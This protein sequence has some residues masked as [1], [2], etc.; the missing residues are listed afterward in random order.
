MENSKFGA[1]SEQSCAIQEQSVDPFPFFGT[2]HA[3]LRTITEQSTIGAIAAMKMCNVS[4]FRETRWP[5]RSDC[6]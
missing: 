4:K 6:E 3:Q 1:I 5:L 2:T